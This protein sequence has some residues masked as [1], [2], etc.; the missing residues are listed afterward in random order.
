RPAYV[1]PAVV[2]LAL[3]A[4]AGIVADR[5]RVTATV[6]LFAALA[7]LVGAAAA[8]A[9]LVR[10]LPESRTLAAVTP[11]VLGPA[12]LLLLV[13]GGLTLVVGGRRPAL[14]VA[15]CAVLAPAMGLE[16]PAAGHAHPAP[17]GAGLCRPAEH[18]SPRRGLTLRVRHLRA[19]RAR[20]RRACRGGPAAHGDVA[21][22]PRPGR[23]WDRDQR[24]GRPRLPAA[25][26]HRRRGRRPA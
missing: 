21:R 17:T 14:A 10:W 25:R 22:A 23:R 9:A 24:P 15:A 3:L 1:L 2:P 5:A 18:P 20:R 4:A 19:R 6:R 7:A 16:P 8:G 13:W 11:A 26:H 12:G